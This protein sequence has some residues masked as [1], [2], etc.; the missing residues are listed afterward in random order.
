VQFSPK[1]R[2]R[3]RKNLLL[4]AG[5]WEPTITNHIRGSR[6]LPR[7]AEREKCGLG[8]EQKNYATHLC[9]SSFPW[10]LASFSLSLFHSLLLPAVVVVSGWQQH[11]GH[12]IKS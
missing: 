9:I 2:R 1:K 5:W 3:R 12:K 10:P 4:A 7:T 8:A 6:R 11:R